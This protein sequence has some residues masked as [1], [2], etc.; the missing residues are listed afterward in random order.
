MKRT[1]QGFFDRSTNTE[2]HRPKKETDT[3]SQA[4][5]DAKAYLESLPIIKTPRG[6]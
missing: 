5:K 4:Y 2:T 6:L 1:K 3:D